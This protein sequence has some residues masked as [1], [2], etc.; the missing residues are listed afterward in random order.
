MTCRQ[1]APPNF[2]VADSFVLSE[3]NRIKENDRSEWQTDFAN[4]RMSWTFKYGWDAIEKKFKAPD[5][6][7]NDP[8]AMQAYQQALRSE[9]IE[10]RLIP[11][12][13]VDALGDVIGDFSSRLRYTQIPWAKVTR[14]VN[15]RGL[16][17]SPGVYV[18]IIDNTIVNPFT[19]VMGIDTDDD[20]YGWLFSVRSNLEDG[21]VNVTFLLDQTTD[22]TTLRPWSPTG[23]ISFAS[24]S[25]GYD[26]ATGVLTM[27]D[28][29][30]STTDGGQF[31]GIDF[32]VGDTVCITTY[33]NNGA[34]PYFRETTVLAVAANGSTMTVASG[35]GALDTNVESIVVI[36]DWNAP[37]STARRTG[38]NRVSF[39]GSGDDLLIDGTDRLHK[40]S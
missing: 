2:S 37:A 36:T 19:G 18:K 11:A 10:D 14:S 35:L 7:I 24:A 30:R 20:L 16:L 15:K 39:Q 29:F 28:R 1:L 23:L 25:N 40:F 6:T 27:D 4:V 34:A 22:Q 3:S 38:A 5:I 12:S 17:L 32:L 13:Q 33:D 9:T 8:F 31:D 26:N 21:S